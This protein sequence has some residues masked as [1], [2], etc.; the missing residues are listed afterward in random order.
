MEKILFIDVKSPGERDPLELID[1]LAP[2]FEKG[3][4]LFEDA[5]LLTQLPGWR[6][7]LT[8]SGIRVFA[9]E[10]DLAARGFVPGDWFEVVNYHRA[11]ELIMGEYD[12]VVNV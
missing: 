2:G 10:D 4:L 5:V 9:I 7:K 11:A 8:E 6:S 3:M 12:K 1:L